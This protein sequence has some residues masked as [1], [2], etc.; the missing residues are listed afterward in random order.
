MKSRIAVMVMLALLSVAAFASGAPWF[1]WMNKFDR[2]IVCSQL[3]P[4]EAWVKYQ[5]P[6]SESRCSKP[7][8]PQ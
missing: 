7:G 3:S 8:N 5:G 2:T 4:G 1:K 6:F